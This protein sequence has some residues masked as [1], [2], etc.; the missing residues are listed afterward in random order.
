MEQVNNNYTVMISKRA[1]QM[2][3]NHAIF[4]SQ[5][6]EDAAEHLVISFENASKTLE[7]MPQRCPWLIGEFIPR[8]VYRYLIFEKRYMLIYQIKDNKVYVDYVLDCRQDYEWLF[9]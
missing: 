2:L 9:Q 7:Q 4:L 5:V 6:N 1:T 8:N 3:V